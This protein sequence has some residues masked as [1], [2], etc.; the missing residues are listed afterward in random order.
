M[1]K[2][3]ARRAPAAPRPDVSRTTPSK[4]AEGGSIESRAAFVLGWLE[5]HATKA[6][7][8]GMARYGIPSTGAFGVTMADMRRLAKELGK[9]HELAAALWATARYEARLVASLV[10]E[11]SKVTPAQMESWSRDFDSWAICDT[12]C[13]ALFDRTPHAFAKVHAWSKRSDEFQKRAAFALLA[14]L[15]VHAKST[16]DEAFL[17]GLVLVER[18]ANDGR[19]FVKKGVSW[20]L[21]SIGKKRNSPA[22]RDAAIAL[23]QRL[24]TE[25]GDHARSI[26][27]EAL[28]ELA[29]KAKKAKKTS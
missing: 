18:E 15:T 2:V 12:V 4:D 24:A 13:F 27:K 29:P 19:H 8:D 23:A 3:S 14:S 10:D 16:P 22:L 26:G 20:A 5:A 25:G 28:R 9:S 11:P 21:R 7:L 6:T 1:K 17:E